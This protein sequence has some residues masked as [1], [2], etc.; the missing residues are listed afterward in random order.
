MLLKTPQNFKKYRK[1]RIAR[2]IAL[3]PT[4]CSGVR[5]N[6]LAISYKYEPKS[7]YNCLT[8]GLTFHQIGSKLKSAV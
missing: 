3:I 2:A 4:D 1:E 6:K 7:I 8:V 5:S